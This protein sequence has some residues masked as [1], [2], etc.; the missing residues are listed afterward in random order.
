MRCG[1]STAPPPTTTG[2]PT[3]PARTCSIWARGTH[4][5]AS[6]AVTRET[7]YHGA[8]DRRDRIE[9]RSTAGSR[10]RG[11]RPPGRPRATGR[12]G[13]PS[14]ARGGHRGPLQARRCPSRRPRPVRSTGRAGDH[15][16]RHRG[17]PVLVHDGG[18]HRRPSGVRWTRRDGDDHGGEHLSR[19]TAPVPWPIRRRW[20]SRLVTGDQAT[21]RS[22]CGG[23]MSAGA[24]R[25]QILDRGVCF[26]PAALDEDAWTVSQHPGIDP[27]HVGRLRAPLSPAAHVAVHGSCSGPR[28]APRGLSGDPMWSRPAGDPP[29]V[30]GI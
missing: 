3:P 4:S 21:P 10:H 20:T 29:P 18:A 8:I 14:A 5:S 6:G 27:P 2:H 13:W 11:R 15:P 19:S 16:L 12:S 17:G 28:A 30:L 25:L 7:H 1:E 9:D 26:P 23:W 24:R 22:G